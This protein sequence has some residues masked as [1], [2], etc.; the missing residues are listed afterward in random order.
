[1]GDRLHLSQDDQPGRLLPQKPEPPTLFTDHSFPTPPGGGGAGIDDDPARGADVDDDDSFTLLDLLL[2]LFA[3]AIYLAEVI[4]WLVTVLPGLILDIATFPAREV[5]YWTVVVPAWNLFMLSRRALVMSGFLMPK[6]EEVDLGLTTLGTSGGFDI[7]A[8]LDDPFAIGATATAITEPSGRLTPTSTFGIDPAYPRGIVRDDPDN[9]SGIDIPAALGLTGRL[10]YAGDG[11]AEFKP[12]EWVAPWRYPLKNQN[13]DWVAQEGA[14][15]HVGPYLAGDQSTVLLPGPV[16]DGAARKDLEAAGSP[17]E[18]F[19]AL[20]AL[21][22]ENRHLGGPVDYSTYLIGRM[23][24][25]RGKPEFGVP[26]F[27]LDSDRG[28]AWQCWDWDRHHLGRDPGRPNNRGIWE[29]VP[30]HIA[31]PQSDFSYPQPCT[32]PQFFHADHDNPRQTDGAGNPLDS[33]WYD[34]TLDLKA[35]Y[36]DRAVDPPPE[37]FGDD[38]CRANPGKPHDPVT[39]SDWRRHLVDG[40]DR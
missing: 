5:I 8:A 20:D 4:I 33:Q 22:A 21:L 38:P 2:A 7:A 30:D 37:P 28:Y 36:L 26:D 11:G 14:A 9:V 29:C 10:R 27:N 25:E 23:V 17:G 16:G 12:S 18:T 24:A 15:A 13:D 3:W 6:P 1:M 35:H 34:P 40:A 31:T 19:A 39:G 32:P